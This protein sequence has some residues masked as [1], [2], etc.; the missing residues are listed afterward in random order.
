[1]SSQRSQRNKNKWD[2]LIDRITTE[3][4]A[5]KSEAKGVLVIII[6]R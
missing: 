6:V 5:K 3:N 1:V 4:L 2:V